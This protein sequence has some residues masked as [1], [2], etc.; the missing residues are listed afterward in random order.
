[1]GLQSLCVSESTQGF[2]L[3]QITFNPEQAIGKINELTKVQLPRA[4]YNALNKALF[5]TREAFKSRSKNIFTKTVPFTENSILYD[6]PQ[7]SGDSLH[8]RLFI[9]DQATKG[10]APANYLLPQI[11]GGEVY[12]TRFQ[13]RLRARGFLGGSQ[14]SYMRPIG[15]LPK[16]EYVRALWGISAFEDLRL[17]GK[18]G[19]RNYR[20]AGSYVFVPRNL[21]ALA[22]SNISPELWNRV[23]MLQKANNGRIPSSG[24]YK[25]NKNSLDQKFQMLDKTPRVK[26]KFDFHAFAED[27]VED[28]F[29]KELRKNILR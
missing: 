18:Y 25:V 16:G 11:I 21:F 7:R 5:E 13:R 6:K 17:S 3:M 2:F 10:N 12:P 8:A 22:K 23:K 28:V 4:S 19:K 1:M 26:R 29:V 20:T 9:R 15:D 14:G 27:V 24:I